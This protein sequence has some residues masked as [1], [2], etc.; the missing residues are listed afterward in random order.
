MATHAQR[1]AKAK[2]AKRATRTQRRAAHHHKPHRPAGNFTVG[3]E[4]AY[5]DT[6]RWHSGSTVAMRDLGNGGPW[7][8]MILLTGQHS[9]TGAIEERLF[10]TNE[11]IF[12]SPQEAYQY[13]MRFIEDELGVEY[14]GDDDIC[15]IK[16]L[17]REKGMGTE[18][19][20]EDATIRRSVKLLTGRDV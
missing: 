11:E 13:G 1:A 18:Y 17:D 16:V 6:Y 20:G 2:K 10:V 3:C 14:I 15:S 9:V 19:I 5:G 7:I 12:A 4:D 8:C